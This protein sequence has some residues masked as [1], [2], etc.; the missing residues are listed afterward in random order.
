MNCEM[1]Q[2]LS[3]GLLLRASHDRLLFGTTK[4]IKL[5]Y[6]VDCEYFRW[7]HRDT[8]GSGLDFLPLWS[9]LR[10]IDRRD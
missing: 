7:N 5:I 10:Y 1:V 8:N 9:V 2:K 6:L 3:Y 4:L